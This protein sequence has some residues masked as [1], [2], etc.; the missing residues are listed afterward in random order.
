MNRK[1]V[2]RRAL[3]GRPNPVYLEI[4]VKRGAAFRGVTAD[5]KIAVD[6]AFRIPPLY[7]RLA[8]AKARETHYFEVTSDAFFANEAEF[9]EQ[10]R[11]DVALIDG[12]HTYAQVLADV[13][14]TLRYLKDDGV[15]VVHDCNPALE[16]I[17]YPAESIAD[18]SAQHHWWNL[19]WSGDVWKAIVHLRSTRDDL[20]VAVLKCDFGVGI[21]RKGPPDSRLPYTV[22][23]VQA[24]GYSDLAADRRRLLNLK[25]PSY[26]RE[27]LAT[28][29][30]SKR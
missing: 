24:L 8:E 27:F 28:E 10:R 13:E 26:L 5:Q 15:I 4:G 6:P 23:E 22:E 21:I 1:K 16:S 7:R 9:L 17:G 3:D 19:L 11:V 14:N 2:V 18:F 12:L 25:P 20:R 29:R 30:E